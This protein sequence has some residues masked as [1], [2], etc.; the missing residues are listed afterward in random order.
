MEFECDFIASGIIDVNNLIVLFLQLSAFLVVA[1]ILGVEIA[2]VTDACF[3]LSLIV[4]HLFG[5]D[6]RLKA[7]ILCQKFFC[8]HVDF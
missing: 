3:V 5:V 6:L 2:M 1:C 7:D 4:G 8:C